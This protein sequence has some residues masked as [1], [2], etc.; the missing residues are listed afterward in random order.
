[1]GLVLCLL[2]VFVVGGGAVGRGLFSVVDRVVFLRAGVCGEGS[3]GIVSCWGGLEGRCFLGLGFV[4]LLSR[5]WFTGFVCLGMVLSQPVRSTVWL[6]PVTNIC[7]VNGLLGILGAEGIEE[8]FHASMKHLLCLITQM[9]TLADV[10]GHICSHCRKHFCRVEASVLG[11]SH[12]LA[13]LLHQYLLVRLYSCYV[14]RQLATLNLISP[15]QQP[16]ITS[17]LS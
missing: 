17:P 4:P 7:V 3:G 11:P 16:N 15:F 12:F 13:L 10:Q 8:R 6:E 9:I 2:S 14:D 5:R 1:M